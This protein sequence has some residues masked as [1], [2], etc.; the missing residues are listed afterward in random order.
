V[1]TGALGKWGGKKKTSIWGK[2]QRLT[3][4]KKKFAQRSGCFGGGAYNINQKSRKRSKERGGG[5]AKKV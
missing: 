5:T 2:I 3:E 4:K 1:R